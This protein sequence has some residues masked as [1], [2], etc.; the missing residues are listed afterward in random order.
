MATYYPP[1]PTCDKCNT[2]Q[3]FAGCWA[4][5]E[6]QSCSAYCNTG[7]NCTC[8]SANRQTICIAHSQYIKDHA[9]VGQFLWGDKTDRDVQRAIDFI[10]LKWNKDF[11]D[12][13]IDQLNTAENIGKN[14]RQKTNAGS[15]SVNK[16]IQGDAIGHEFYNN[17]RLKLKNFNNI[18]N[19]YT[20]VEKEELITAALANTLKQ[21]F[22]NAQFHPNVC[23]ICNA[24]ELAGSRSCS[25][26]CSCSCSCGCPCPCSCSANK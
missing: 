9:D 19:S 8:N 3:S 12:R 15:Y 14:S 22:N 24:N 21:A 10:H 5:V 6:T 2:A 4:S 11:W 18:P 16:P 20:E 13:L 1:S 26:N 17:I 25:C 23:D 7:C